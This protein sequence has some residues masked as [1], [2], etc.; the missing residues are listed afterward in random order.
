MW[1]VGH[2]DTVI[3]HFR[4]L[5]DMLQVIALQ[6]LIRSLEQEYFVVG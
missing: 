4:I 5:F 3:L 1:V 6:V 2:K